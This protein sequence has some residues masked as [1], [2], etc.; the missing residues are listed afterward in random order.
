MSPDPRPMPIWKPGGN[1]EPPVSGSSYLSLLV[2]VTGFAD[3]DR[4]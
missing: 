3:F 4:S 1:A 2:V